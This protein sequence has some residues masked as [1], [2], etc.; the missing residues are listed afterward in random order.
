MSVGGPVRGTI[1]VNPH[2]SGQIE[3]D[4]TPQL[5]QL[6]LNF[7]PT[8]EID[9]QTSTGALVLSLTAD[10]ACTGNP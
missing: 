1:T 3:F 7:D 5:G 4:T 9:V 10:A 6:L 2:G 8:G